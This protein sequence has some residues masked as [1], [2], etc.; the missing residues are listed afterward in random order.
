MENETTILLSTGGAKKKIEAD[1]A[2]ASGTQAPTL[3]VY[4]YK[5]KR[6]RKGA[7][8]RCKRTPVFWCGVECCADVGEQIKQKKK[9]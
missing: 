5:N 7:I 2:N 3:R 6:E 4:V 9:S 1:S 8:Q